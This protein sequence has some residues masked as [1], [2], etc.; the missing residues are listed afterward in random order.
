MIS[1]PAECN[2]VVPNVVL[3]SL[4]VIVFVPAV[5][6]IL[7]KCALP[8]S[9]SDKVPATADPLS[10]NVPLSISLKLLMFLYQNNSLN[11]VC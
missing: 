8:I 9:L 10:I 11:L 4:T 6:T 2:N 5:A 1:S 3:P 7:T